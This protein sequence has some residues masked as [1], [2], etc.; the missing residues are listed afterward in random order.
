[1]TESERIAMLRQQNA[2]LRREAV[3]MRSDI[4]TLVDRCEAR[5]TISEWIDYYVR[6]GAVVVAERK[7]ADRLRKDLQG[8][9]R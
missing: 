4:T 5:A 1:V 8:K 2:Q 3:E 9:A 7:E 6:V